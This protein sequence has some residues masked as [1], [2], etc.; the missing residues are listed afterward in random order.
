NAAKF[1]VAK[2]R[3]KWVSIDDMRKNGIDVDG[4][5][6]VHN[7]G[8]VALMDEVCTGKAADV[9]EALKNADVPPERKARQIALAMERIEKIDVSKM[10][11]TLT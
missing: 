6:F 7:G 10:I 11:F 4:E 9:L 8:M 3:Q 5:E 2:G 1:E